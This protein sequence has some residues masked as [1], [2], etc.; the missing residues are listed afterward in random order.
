MKTLTVCMIVKNEKELL[1]RCLDS[2]VGADELIICDT[3]S[4]DNTVEI[5]KKYTE[6][7][8]TDYLWEDSYEKARNHALTKC[9]GG[10][11]LSIDADEILREGDMA[12]IRDAIENAKSEE[13]AFDIKMQSE[14]G[15]NEFWFPRLFKRDP[16][17]FWKG[18]VHNHLSVHGARKLDV[19][20]TYGYSPAHAADKD[21]ALRILK[22]EIARDPSL[23]RE[24]FYL[25]REYMYRKDWDSAIDHYQQ[26]LSRSSWTA[27]MA[28]AYF[29]LSKC[30]WNKR[31]LK[32]AQEACLG[33]IRIN[34]H[35]KEAVLFMASISGPINRKRWTEFA[36][37]ATNEGVVFIRD[38]YTAP[39]EKKERDASYYDELFSKSADMSRYNQIYEE[40]G[41]WVGERKV[42]DVGCGVAALRKYI[43]NYRGFDFSKGA[44]AVANDN[45]VI[46][47]D[48]CS[49]QK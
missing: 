25:A 10:W 29:M 31:M 40:I 9:T 24:R 32:E 6:K 43:P 5:A 21:R 1:A 44:V 17:V 18:A 42:L 16:R 46:V 26:Y 48:E 34:T 7:V 36:E 2:V 4:T 41:T 8:F 33:A 3:G 14:K 19:E 13:L 11:V 27:Q 39:K 23:S 20:I 47:A 37:G 12:K 38:S 22:K 15:N 30:Y 45:R 35:F 49:R 28:E